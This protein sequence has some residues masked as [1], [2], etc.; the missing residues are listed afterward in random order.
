MGMQQHG[1]LPSGMQ[2]AVVWTAPREKQPGQRPYPQETQDTT[3][4]QSQLWQC[5]TSGDVVP[6]LCLLWPY[7]PTAGHALPCPRWVPKGLSKEKAW[8][9]TPRDVMAS[10]SKQE[11]L[12]AGCLPREFM[13]DTFQP[14]HSPPLC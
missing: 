12:E 2:T 6:R 13:S 14:P 3:Q 10:P 1:W 11:V 9:G 8:E 4:A 7:T 5:S